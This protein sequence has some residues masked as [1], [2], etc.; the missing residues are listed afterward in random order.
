MP[1]EKVVTFSATEIAE[2]LVKERGITSGHWGLFVRFGL[3][4]V[5]V[6]D[7]KTMFPAAVVTVQEIGIQQFPEPNPLTVDAGAL[8]SAD[9]KGKGKSLRPG[10]HVK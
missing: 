3:G 5:N 1:E 10:V 2:R 9:R 6:G 7:G 4:A 8:A